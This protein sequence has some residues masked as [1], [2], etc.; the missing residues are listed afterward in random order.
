MSR[1]ISITDINAPEL[2]IYARLTEAQLKREE[3]LFIAESVKVIKVALDKGLIPVSFL[4]EERQIEGIGKELIERCPDVPVYTAPREALSKL[5]G[6]ELTRGVLCAMKRPERDSLENVLK[7]AKRVAVLERLSDAVNVGAIFRS[8]AA[9]GLDAVLLFNNC[10]EPLNRRTARVSM[11][12]V[13][14]VPWAFF[15]KENFPMPQNAVEYLKSKGFLTAALALKDDTINI[16]DQILNESEKIAL[17][18]GAEG[19]G[20]SDETIN[21]CDYTVK[22]PMYHEVDSLNVAAA[23]AVAFWE[24]GKN[25]SECV[26]RNSEL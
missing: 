10:S 7:N 23:A 1:I 11:G 24:I 25:N 19:D 5:T 12:S 2:N 17:F 13:F 4:M 21:A 14:L 8:A 16:N 22:I 26:M 6:F 9:L 18:L 15:N 3:G 20:L